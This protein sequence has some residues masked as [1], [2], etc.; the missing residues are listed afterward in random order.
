MAYNYSILETLKLPKIPLTP[1]VEKLTELS[2]GDLGVSKSY[3]ASKNIVSS[4]ELAISKYEKV[5]F[6]TLSDVTFKPL[7]VLAVLPKALAKLEDII[8]ISLTTTNFEVTNPLN[9]NKSLNYK[10]YSESKNYND[11]I[12]SIDRLN[13]D[14]TKNISLTNDNNN[15]LTDNINLS[16]SAYKVISIEYSTGKRIDNID[17]KYIYNV[18]PIKTLGAQSNIINTSDDIKYPDVIIFDVYD[19]NFK[20]L[21]T[22]DVPDFIKDN[23]KFYINY[24][25]SISYSKNIKDI[26]DNIISNTNKELKAKNI[27]ETTINNITSTLAKN[28][29]DNTATNILSSGYISRQ[30]YPVENRYY[31]PTFLNDKNI[32]IDI[33]KIYNL[34]LFDVEA[35]KPNDILNQ[36]DTKYPFGVWYDG[37]SIIESKL[38]PNLNISDIKYYERVRNINNIKPLLYNPYLYN[39]IT[40][41]QSNI[42]YK[43]SDIVAYNNEY[44]I[45]IKNYDINTP[46]NI[47]PLDTSYWRVHKFK[48]Y[49]VLE[50]VY[51]GEN[52][53]NDSIKSPLLNSKTSVGDANNY[54]I[55]NIPSMYGKYQDLI[56]DVFVYT[57]PELYTL[58]NVIKNPSSII[59]ESILKNLKTSFDMFDDISFDIINL[60]RSSTPKKDI[61]N[62]RKQS[63]KKYTHVKNGK[64]FFSFNSYSSIKLFD[65]G[66]YLSFING[67]LKLDDIIYT[68][69]NSMLNSI[70]GFISI[71][72]IFI[73]K[74]VSKLI[75][76]FKKLNIAN[77]V[78]S[79]T[80]FLSFKWL[81]DI[82]DP[83]FLLSIIGITLNLSKIN[84]Y[85]N[86]SD[87]YI[88][89]SKI[90][91]IS[92]SE[93]LPIV[94]R[95][96]FNTYF[97]KSNIFMTAIK[98]LLSF[99]TDMLNTLIKSIIELFN[100]PKDIIFPKDIN[101]SSFV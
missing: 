85:K 91:D 38:I 47:T 1:N 78:S 55:K 53:N 5:I 34:Q 22:N 6:K 23:T 29:D 36:F 81:T 20:K 59:Y 24:T 13:P 88:D 60:N 77:M 10:L 14:T 99:I 87:K 9:Y 84:E 58:L 73:E 97:N 66:I 42:R 37:I 56:I 98:N 95:D 17:Y 8:S 80:E 65:K 74:I 46:N 101:L 68:K 67:A 21:S 82:I 28:I 72:F 57:L 15:Y 30:K 16:N 61:K 50:G 31:N 44:Y 2:G 64:S 69:T 92:F 71:P 41:Y 83:L 90:I 76:L 33:E 52:K 40:R 35:C 3:L 26:K 94:S 49:K 63:V 11:N 39:T 43:I 100:L 4:S 75:E 32:K 51:N 79:I 27:D 45:C 96:V 25:D 89:L 12:R 86:N 62:S 48:K 7:N 18:I 19:D 54:K 70:L 93:K